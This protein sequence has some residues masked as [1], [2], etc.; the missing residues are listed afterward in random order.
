M[1][2]NG[3]SGKPGD[4]A[5]STAEGCGIRG[6]SKN[7]RRHPED[8]G[9][10]ETRRLIARRCW[11][12]ED[13]GKPG[14]SPPVTLKDAG[15]EETR[16]PIAGYSR[17]MQDS[18]KPGDSSR[19]D[20]G[21]EDS[22]QPGDLPPAPPKDAGIEE[23]RRT[24]AGTALEM[25]DAR[26]LAASSAKLN[27]TMQGPNA[28]RVHTIEAPETPVSGVF[29]LC[30]LALL[31]SYRKL[32]RG[33]ITYGAVWRVNRHSRLSMA[34]HRNSKGRSTRSDLYRFLP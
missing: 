23:T 25:Q 17:K 5:T 22:G 1:L 19:G 28:L 2:R 31:I 20:A 26:K 12:N 33:K 6:N 9:F 7:H 16:R 27:G 18:G 29:V 4:F 11:R 30:L 24:I 8:A 13:S 32:G 34:T 21:R 10:G 3:Y 14:E 15:F